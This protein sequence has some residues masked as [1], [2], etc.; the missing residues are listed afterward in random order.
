MVTLEVEPS[1]VRVRDS[2][3]GLARVVADN[4]AGREW[5]QV[6]LKGSDPERL[7]RV[8]WASRELRVPPGGTAGD[9]SPVRSPTAGGRNRGEPHDH[10]QRDRWALHIDRYCHI[11][12][13]HQ[14]LTDD[15]PWPPRI[16][17]SIIRVNDADAATAQVTIDHHRDGPQSASSWMVQ[18]IRNVP[19]GSRSRRKWWS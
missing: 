10:T 12:A 3:V 1:L 7:V 4:R 16:E 15:N 19:S 17:P 13:I 11:R 14:R 9:G 18:L 6:Q 2:T 5:A 8:T